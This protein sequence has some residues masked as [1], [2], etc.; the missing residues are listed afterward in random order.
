MRI[1]VADDDRKLC[2]VIKRGSK[3]K[4]MPWIVCMTVKKVCI[5]PKAVCTTSLSWIS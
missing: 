2:D 3:K 5:M 4:P 1:L